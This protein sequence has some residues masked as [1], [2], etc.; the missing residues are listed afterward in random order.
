[1]G[2][3]PAAPKPLFYYEV[4]LEPAVAMCC[5]TN[6]GLAE[7]QSAKPQNFRWMAHLPL[8]YPKAVVDMLDKAAAA[9][10]C[11]VIA[12]T[13]IAGRIDEPDYE[14]F[15]SAVEELDMPV[16]LHPA[17]EH[18]SPGMGDFYLGSVIG[19]LTDATI[20]LERLDLPQGMLDRHPKARIISALGGGFFPYQVGRPAAVHFIPGPSDARE[21]RPLGTM[22]A[23]S[24]STQTSTK[25]ASLK[26]LIEF[27]GADNVTLGTTGRSRPRTDN[28]FGMLDRRWRAAP[29]R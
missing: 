28:P 29:R 26:F 4:D 27:A 8:R 14:I 3:M 2:I 21:E 25:N 6:L 13:S 7:Y 17:Y 22:S 18:V 1:M 20:A 5:E 23:R 19:T 9:G 24:S 10:C 11:G 12:G 16:L 15:W